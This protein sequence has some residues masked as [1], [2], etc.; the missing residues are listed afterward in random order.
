MYLLIV[1]IKDGDNQAHRPKVF[2]H[3]TAVDYELHEEDMEK[4]G[5]LSF[6]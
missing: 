6:R 4:S 5:Y 1:V 3:E 2:T